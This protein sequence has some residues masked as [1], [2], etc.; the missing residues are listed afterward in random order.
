M[1]RL[2]DRGS[3]IHDNIEEFESS[4]NDDIERSFEICG[5]L[6]ECPTEVWV[7]N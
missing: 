4:A 5:L 7:E 3:V 6:Q 1:V 2:I